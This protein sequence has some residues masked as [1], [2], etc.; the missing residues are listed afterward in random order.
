MILTIILL[1]VAK[2]QI[3]YNLPSKQIQFSSYA[4]AQQNFQKFMSHINI[5]GAR[6]VTWNKLHTED[7]E[8]LGAT[9]QNL[10]VTAT[11]RPGFVHRCS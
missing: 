2:I 8:I 4:G 5:Q 7:T 11:R 6:R 3:W 9:S 10:V 1:H